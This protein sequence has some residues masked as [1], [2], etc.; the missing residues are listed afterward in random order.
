M[1]K[2]RAK[3]EIAV[4]GIDL[5]K[6]WVQVCGQDGGGRCNWSVR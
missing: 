2:H 6:T 5:G 1:S 4:V 3:Q